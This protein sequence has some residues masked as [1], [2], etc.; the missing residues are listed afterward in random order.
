MEA[1]QKAPTVFVLVATNNTDAWVTMALGGEQF[2]FVLITGDQLNKKTRTA[3]P[4]PSKMDD[5]AIT[6]F[7][8]PGSQDKH[9]INSPMFMWIDND[10]AKCFLTNAYAPKGMNSPMLTPHQIVKGAVD[11][12]TR[13]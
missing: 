3:P 6:T 4:V 12:R 5:M 13:Y 10:E 8:P 7:L 11:P 1:K 9:K 2:R